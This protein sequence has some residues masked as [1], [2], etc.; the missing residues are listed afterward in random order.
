MGASIKRVL[1]T[2]GSGYV[3]RHLTRELLQKFPDI[4]VNS[5][6]RSE[7]VISE[8]MAMC[9][10][11]RLKIIMGDIRDTEAVR[12]ATRGM[13]AVFH[14]AAM[15]R[16][17]LSEMHC[18]EAVST[19]V[20]GTMNVLDVFRGNTFV[21]MSTDKAVEPVNCYGASKLVAEKLVM[22][23][24]NK[25]NRTARYMIIR[26][27]NI[28][29]STGSVLEIWKRQIAQ[30]NE[31]TVTNLNMLRYYTTIEGVVKLL[32]AV[33]VRGENDKIY[34]TPRGERMILKELVD[35]VIERYGNEKTR[36]KIIGMRPGERLE[37]KLRVAD[38]VNVIA[39]FEETDLSKSAAPI[40]PAAILK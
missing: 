27:G 21:L 11:D 4:E 40:K 15:K 6:S 8:L 12:Y 31:I 38:E 39:G 36:V 24:A 19:N 14:M 33:M 9:S 28:S 1:I 18:R 26:S 29:G 35:E 13:D 37:E 16:V 10:S 17:D 23:Q 5:M 3:G 30:S 22:E 25:Q 2:G 20:I 7:T 34:V 32:I